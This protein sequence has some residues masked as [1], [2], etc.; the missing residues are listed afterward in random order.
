MCGICGKINNN[1][2]P[3]SR[4]LLNKMTEVLSHRGP[5]QGKTYISGN[6]GLGHRRLSIIDLSAA[7]SQPMSNEDETVWIVLNGEIYNFL[8]LRENLEEKGHIFKSRSD[9][10]VIIHLYEELGTACVSKLKGMFA[11]AIWDEKNK[12][13]FLARDR[14][15]K[16]PLNYVIRNGNLTFAS[17]I[18]S[19]L[20]DTDISR[21]INLRAIDRYLTYL[22]VPGPETI[23]IGIKKLPPAHILIYEKGHIRIEQYWDISFTNKIK[24]SEKE[25][26]DKILELL[27]NAVRMRMISDVPLGVFLS[28]GIDSSAITAIMCKI[29]SKPVKTFSIGFKDKS[30]NELEYAREVA[31]LF[32]TEHYEYIVEPK[33]IEILPKLAWHYNE[34]FADS[35]AIPTYYLSKMARQ[36]VAVALSGDGGDESFAGYDRYKASKLADIYNLIPNSIHNKLLML[37]GEMPEST[38]KKD[39]IRNLKKFLRSIRLSGQER[40]AVWMSNF[41]RVGKEKLYSAEFKNRLKTIDNGDYLLSAYAKSITKD[42]IDAMLFV[43]IITY[44]PGD[45]L[46]KVDI[47]SMANSLEVRSP[48]LDQ[49]LMEFMGTIPSS[50]KLRWFT[51]KYI[52]KKTLVKIIPERILNRKKSG[53]GVPVGRWIKEELRDFT[54]DTLLGANAIRRGYFN[55]GVIKQLLEEH[56]SGRIN[57]A[58]RIWSLINLEIWHQ[59]F[60]DN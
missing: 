35:S 47:A 13:L 10:E 41:G 44:L 52:L 22:Y 54:C 2:K 24:L 58:H 30:F 9:T 14:V 36:E 31:K 59:V 28:G 40:Y 43:D 38:Q 19:I 15:G 26:Q 20:Q 1:S 5:D 8:E 12:K 29:S 34:P 16:K 39:F 33:T 48:F 21:E 11:F 3:I 7:A 51:T 25:C 45:L 53:F 55:K 50:F 37:V 6:V 4:Q 46:V 42:S 57:H 18:K 60:I 56:I 17:E 27:I 32:H 23:F 49:D